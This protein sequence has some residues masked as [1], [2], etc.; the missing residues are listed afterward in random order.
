MIDI[1]EASKDGPSRECRF[2][3]TWATCATNSISSSTTPS[4]LF[5]PLPIRPSTFSSLVSTNVR[6]VLAASLNQNIAPHRTAPSRLSGLDSPSKPLKLRVRA[7]VPSC[8]QVTNYDTVEDIFG[9][10]WFRAFI[11]LSLYAFGSGVMAFEILFLNSIRRPY[12]SCGPTMRN[13]CL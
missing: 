12:V 10:G 11:I 2:Q 5:S 1:W 4:V 8:S 6:E 3:S 9:E 7:L 13:L